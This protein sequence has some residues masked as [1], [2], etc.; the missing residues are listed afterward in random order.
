M[1]KT[2]AKVSRHSDIMSRKVG[3]ATKENKALCLRNNY[4]PYLNYMAWCKANQFKVFLMGAGTRYVSWKGKIEFQL[5][6]SHA[7]P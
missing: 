7:T 3:S 4:I 5:I 6:F 2:G 1:Q